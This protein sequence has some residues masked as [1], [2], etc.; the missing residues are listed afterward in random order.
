M[1]LNSCLDNEWPVKPWLEA[2]PLDGPVE[3]IRR[4]GS[5]MRVHHVFWVTT[6]FLLAKM[7]RQ[8]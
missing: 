4:L 8:C 3:E 7:Y 5:E 6:R 1:G 2:L